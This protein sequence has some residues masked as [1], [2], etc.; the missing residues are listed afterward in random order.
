MA[1]QSSK[2]LVVDTTTLLH[3]RVYRRK[4]TRRTAYDRAVGNSSRGS[5]HLLYAKVIS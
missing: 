1:F 2:L 3:C 5:E 4:R